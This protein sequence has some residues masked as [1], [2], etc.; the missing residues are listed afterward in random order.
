[1]ISVWDYDK[2]ISVSTYVIG[3]PFFNLKTLKS[4]D[5]D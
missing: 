1:M 5:E 4:G 2:H 3:D